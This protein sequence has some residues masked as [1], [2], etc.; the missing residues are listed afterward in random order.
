MS[1]LEEMPRLMR[2]GALLLIL[3]DEGGRELISLRAPC[4]WS[5]SAHPNESSSSKFIPG[6]RGRRGDSTE[7]ISAVALAVVSRGSE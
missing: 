1:L 5:T 7:F 4:N 2:N 6:M 3:K